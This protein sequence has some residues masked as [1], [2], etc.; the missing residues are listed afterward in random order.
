MSALSY[1]KLKEGD[2]QVKNRNQPGRIASIILGAVLAMTPVLQA[3]TC[4]GTGD[5]IGSFGWSGAR[6]TEFVPATA[7]MP[8]PAGS[9]TPIGALLAAAGNTAAFA[10][11]G[12]AYLDGN[13][14]VFASSTPGG[15]LYSVGAYTVNGDCTVSVSLNDAFA[16]SGAAGL[17]PVQATATYQGVLVQDGNEIDLIQT[18]STATSALTLTKTQQSCS[19]GNVLSAFGIT[20][21]GA[22]T[23]V[24]SSTGTTTTTT[25]TT[26]PSSPTPFS[27]VGRFVADGAGNLTTD[28]FG[29]ASPLT[30]R[31]ITGTYTVNTDCT[32]T[33]TLITSDGVK[34]GANFV[35][36]T[37][38]PNLTIG[39]QALEF[40][41][42]DSGVVGVGLAQQQ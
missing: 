23:A 33:A 40:A 35:I 15:T 7:G 22:S 41:F 21:T 18:G 27:I 6:T 29:E 11:V 32:G 24:V 37:Q 17:T 16:T 19:A 14:G 38:G 4:G 2:L 42:S 25:T 36:V 20:A 5:V 28:G 10:T 8:G 31:E 30:S 13:G 34:R 1:Q 12:R 9:A 3:R 26:A 39:T